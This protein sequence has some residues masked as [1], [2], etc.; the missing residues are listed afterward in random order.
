MSPTL[1][2]HACKH[3][4]HATHD[5]TNSTSFLKL[6]QYKWFR[7]SKRSR[8][9]TKKVGVITSIVLICNDRNC[10]LCVFLPRSSTL[11]EK[12]FLRRWF[13]DKSCKTLS[14]HLFYRI[15]D[16]SSLCI[17]KEKLCLTLLLTLLFFLLISSFHQTRLIDWQT[18]KWYFY[19]K[20]LVDLCTPYRENLRRGKVMKIFPG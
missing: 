16:N 2:R 20:W 7:F 1:A 15:P 18:K 6:D 10:C 9:R 11:Q 3:A 19:K 17:V 12:R 5:S 8:G 13:Y 14:E 4:V